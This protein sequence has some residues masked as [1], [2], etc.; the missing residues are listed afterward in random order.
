MDES[1]S[2]SKLIQLTSFLVDGISLFAKKGRMQ[3]KGDCKKSEIAKS[4]I[5]KKVRLQKE[6]RLQKN[7]FYPVQVG[8]DISTHTSDSITDYLEVC[9]PPLS[10]LT[11]DSCNKHKDNCSGSSGSCHHG[12]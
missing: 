4:E 10:H 2:Y 1:L 6:V 7:K 3:K 9:Q 12:V 11:D 5:A 8:L